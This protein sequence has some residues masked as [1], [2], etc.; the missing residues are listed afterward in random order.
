M[1]SDFALPENFPDQHGKDECDVTQASYSELWED[2][3][4]AEDGVITI[5]C[6]VHTLQLSV[7]DFFN[8]NANAKEVGSKVRNVTIK[9]HKQNIIELFNLFLD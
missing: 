1:R 2:V 6:G 3:I 7:L 5:R 4:T 9:T 8:A